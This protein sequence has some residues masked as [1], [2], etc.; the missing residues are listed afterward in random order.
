ML[1]L[2]VHSVSIGFYCMEPLKI[3]FLL[4]STTML[5][6]KM[7]LFYFKED[8][9]GKAGRAN[10]PQL[11]HLHEDTHGAG[12]ESMYRLNELEHSPE[13]LDKL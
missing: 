12:L 11:L 10:L 1:L 5:Y 2:V 3:P 7:H 4:L 9:C 6:T 13:G 8:N